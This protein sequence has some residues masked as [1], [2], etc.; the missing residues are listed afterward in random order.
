V[1]CAANKSDPFHNFPD[2]VDNFSVFKKI[3]KGAD[4]RDYYHYSVE[5]NPVL[6]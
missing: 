6:N 2:V 4:G 5:G 1:R 3:E